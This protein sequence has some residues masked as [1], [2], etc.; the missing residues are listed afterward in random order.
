[1]TDTM[2]S[3]VKLIVS[4]DRQVLTRM[5]RMSVIGFIVTMS[6]SR[7]TDRLGRARNKENDK[8]VVPPNM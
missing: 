3:S 1:M 4:E 2:S 7:T 6:S 5:Q 8:H